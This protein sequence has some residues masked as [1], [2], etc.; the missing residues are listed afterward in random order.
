MEKERPILAIE[1]VKEK[2]DAGEKIEGVHIERLSIGRRQISKPINLIECTIDLLDFNNS[3]FTEDVVVRRC[4]IDNV[5]LSEATFE[6][7]C[8]FKRSIIAHGRVQRANFKGD[9]SF[10]SAMIGFCSFHQSVF[11]EE[12]DFSRTTYKG[13]GTFQEVQF[14]KGANFTHAD[15]PEKATFKK[16]QWGE[17]AIFT[18][19]EIR[20]D[21]ELQDAKFEGDI[22]FNNSVCHLSV[23]LT[24]STLMGRTDFSNIKVDRSLILQGM[25]LG[26]KQGFVFKNAC[27]TSIVFTREIVEGHVF[28]EQDGLYL[29]A[30]REYSFLRTAF[31]RINLFDDEDWA[32]YQFKKCE[33]M[34]T[35]L[36]YNPLKLLH[37]LLEY[38]FLDLGCGYGTKPFRTLGL[39]FILVLSFGFIY[40]LALGTQPSPESYGFNADIVNKLIY[41]FDSSLIAFSGGYSDLPNRICG[42][43]KIIAMIEY[44]IGVVLMGLFIVAFSR[45]VIR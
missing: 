29:E 18:N 15:F 37:R 22:H 25:T 42:S 2:I 44:M 34:G 32:Y 24:Q 3:T 13:E 33:R 8:D 26:P 7:K 27:T 11:N 12:A 19:I 4:T 10:E 23:D 5:V 30:S 35:P 40:F 41:G 43:L 39:S 36:S 20:G 45:K 16:T 28:P 17:K 38:I 31:Q 14:K 1:Q 6:K 21:M 9:A